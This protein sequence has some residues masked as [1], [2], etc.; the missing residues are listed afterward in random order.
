MRGTPVEGLVLR[1]ERYGVG[2][3]VASSPRGD[4]AAEPG[5]RTRA[6]SSNR[7]GRRPRRFDRR[8]CR[9]PRRLL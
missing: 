7:R 3:G 4:P 6:P 5:G 8:P 1:K 9:G 2:A